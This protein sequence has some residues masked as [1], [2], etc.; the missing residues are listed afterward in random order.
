MAHF[1]TVKMVAKPKHPVN[2]CGDSAN[3]AD[4]GETKLI[5][6]LFKMFF[7]ETSLYSDWGFFITLYVNGLRI[8]TAKF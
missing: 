3:K 2:T 6:G 8:Y 7:L 4:K 5:Q 1:S